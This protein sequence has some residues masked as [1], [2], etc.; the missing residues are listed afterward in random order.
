ML[1]VYN[2]LTR[3]K[4]DFH[5]IHRNRVNMFV[6]GPTVYDLSH[7]GHARTYVAYD[8]IARYLRFKGYSLFYLMN[9]TDVD[10]KII[11][12][13]KE[14]NKKP[15]ELAKEFTK[16]FYEDMDLLG[17]NTINLFAKASEY[18]PEIISQIESLIQKK[19]AYVVNGDV[20]Y[21]VT[22]FEDYGKLSHRSIDEI[23]KHRIEPDPK[24]KNPSDFSLWKSRKKDELA[25][26]SPWSKG[27]PGWHIE[28]TAI[29][30]TYFGPIYDIHGGALELIF[31]HHE[32]EIAQAEV[33]TGK[34]PLVK[35]WIHTGILNVRGRKMS[36]SLGNFITIK[37]ILIKYRPEVLR[38]FFA[39]SHYRSN[40]DFKDENLLKAKEALEN[41]HRIYQKIKKFY[42]LAPEDSSSKDKDILK[43]IEEYEKK[44]S[45]AMDNDFNTPIAISHLISF[46]KYIDK[47]V[48][49]NTGKKILESALNTLVRIGDILGLFQDFKQEKYGIE[50]LDDI[51][52]IIMELREH[53]RKTKDWKMSDEIRDRLQKLGIVVED[54][55]DKP[56]WKIE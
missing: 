34:K 13:A 8:I 20:Y 10:D 3:K 42:R 53:F 51:I 44:F 33:Y 9:I 55:S 25:W 19:Y 22:K 12:R 11:K 48:T 47:Q 38:F 35:Y 40:V 15:I 1:K 17:I 32:A 50:K 31:P 5:P 18:I 45:S 39:Q 52:Q 14:E 29:T 2:T 43:K 36:K 6:C 54:T 41:L 46:G 26:D 49:N 28:D 27:R 37:D 4:E 16:N 24:K 23:H 7:M 56:E 21:D 30:I